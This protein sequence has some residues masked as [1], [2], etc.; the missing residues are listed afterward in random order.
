V[1]ARLYATTEE[2]LTESWRPAHLHPP[3][4]HSRGV[5]EH[6]L[7]GGADFLEAATAQKL[8]GIMAKRADS[9]Y[10]PGRRNPAWRTMCRRRK[11]VIDVVDVRDA[12]V[13]AA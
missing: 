11:G 3:N 10:T 13:W 8:E 4:L 9:R 7:G 6:H 2:I 1:L 5:P 12:G